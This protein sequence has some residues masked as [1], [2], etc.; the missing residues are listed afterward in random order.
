MSEF[1]R[2]AHL[3]DIPPGARML[4]DLDEETVVIFNVDGNLYCIA[5][6][7][8]HDGGPLA[9]GELEDCE[10]I[11][12]RHGARF[13][14]KTGAVLSMPAVTPVPAYAVKIED[15]GVYVELPAETW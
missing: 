7:C 11:C 8:T 10:I 12:P 14:I 15:D 5:D 9:D 3:D 6:I 2:V 4:V 1:V 13:D